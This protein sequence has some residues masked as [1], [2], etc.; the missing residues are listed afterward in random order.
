MCCLDFIGATH[1]EVAF[2]RTGV[3]KLA[4]FKP[5]EEVPEVP[6]RRVGGDEPER[7][8]PKDSPINQLQRNPDRAIAC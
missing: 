2:D 6:I 8:V 1:A 5:F 4:L 7:H 3:D